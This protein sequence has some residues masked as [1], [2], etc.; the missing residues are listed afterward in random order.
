M[1]KSKK[2]SDHPMMGYKKIVR[3]LDFKDVSIKDL[4][5]NLEFVKNKEKFGFYLISGFREVQR[6]DFEVITKGRTKEQ[7]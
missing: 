3:Y 2:E 4:L 5:P 7:V 6:H 1:Y